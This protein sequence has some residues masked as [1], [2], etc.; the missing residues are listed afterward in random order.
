LRKQVAVVAI[1]LLLFVVSGTGRVGWL[2]TV[3]VA[4]NSRDRACWLVEDCRSRS[5]S[6]SNGSAPLFLAAS[7]LRLAGLLGKE[8]DVNAGYVLDSERVARLI[9][10]HYPDIEDS[11]IDEDK[12]DEDKRVSLVQIVVN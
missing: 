7:I 4:R 6:R 1:G 5:K 3:G 8:G 10:M 2:R 9:R 11:R 12:R